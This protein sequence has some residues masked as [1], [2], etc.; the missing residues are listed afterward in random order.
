MDLGEVDAT[1]VAVAGAHVPL[2]HHAHLV[3]RDLEGLRE[4]RAR[5]VRVLRGVVHVQLVV[6][7]PGEGVR[8]FE[9]DV[10]LGGLL[11]Q[12][13][14]R[15]IGRRLVR[16]AADERRGRRDD[17]AD[18][19]GLELLGRRGLHALDHVEDRGQYLVLHIDEAE[20]LV[21]DVFAIGRDDRDR[22]SHLEHFLVEE[23]ARR[24][25]GSEEHVLVLGRQVPAMKDL[26]H[27]GELLGL[28]RVER[29]DLRVW[30]LAAQRA[31]EQHAGHTEV[32]GVLAEVRDDPDALDTRD[33]GPDDLERRGYRGLLSRA[34][35]RASRARELVPVHRDD[36]GHHFR[37]LG[38]ELL[39]GR[40]LCEL[41]P[42][43]VAQ[44]RGVRRILRDTDRF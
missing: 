5:A 17:R 12:H 22:R 44:A 34:L 14:D 3:L 39:P 24:L 30:V 36:R 4:A 9:C 43:G 20:G 29:G 27:A 13:V 18:L 19:L 8:Q 35:G 38:D 16:V 6:V 7:P 41:L 2:L 10:L 26:P 32:L 42:V 1:S 33:V 37:L 15:H 25:G 31:H 23:E 21:R 11:R 40:V 28:G